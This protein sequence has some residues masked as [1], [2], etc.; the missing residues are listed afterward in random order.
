MVRKYDD[1]V[2]YQS[3]SGHGL[4]GVDFIALSP[5]GG[6]WLIEV[7]NFRPRI[8]PRNGREYRA[9]RPL[10]DRLARA[11][12]AKFEDSRRLIAI[13]DAWTRRRWWRRLQRWWLWR[14]PDP[15]SS[16][17]FWGEAKRRLDGKALLNVVLWMETPERKTGYDEAV[18][19]RLR[20]LIPGGSQLT[21]VEQD[22]GGELPFGIAEES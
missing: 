5:D 4:K 1:T 12:A 18:E 17:W 16:Y 6:L 20:E 13:V 15:D 19:Q 9:Q 8:S 3:V 2:A 11:V 10:P 22:R 14:R 21:V 7:K